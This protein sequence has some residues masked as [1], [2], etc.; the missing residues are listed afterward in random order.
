MKKKVCLTR[1]TRSFYYM[2]Y[3]HINPITDRPPRSC[4][5]MACL[6]V[7]HQQSCAINSA[8]TSIDSTAISRMM[9]SFQ[10]TTWG[11]Q[12]LYLFIYIYIHEPR[13]CVSANPLP[14]F[15]IR[16]SLLSLELEARSWTFS[17][18]FYWH[19]Q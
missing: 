18:T 15:F 14:A 9:V 7:H 4:K 2:Y 3:V 8:V 6:E 12:A 5:R 19:W 1:E 11:E 16:S 10:V 17:Q 13:C